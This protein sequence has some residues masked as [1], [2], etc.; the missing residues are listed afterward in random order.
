MTILALGNRTRTIAWSGEV[1][2][3]AVGEPEAAEIPATLVYF[4]KQWADGMVGGIDEDRGLGGG[5]AMR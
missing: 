4:I 2:E 5:S 1:V 3:V